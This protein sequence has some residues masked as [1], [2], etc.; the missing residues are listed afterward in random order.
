MELASLWMDLRRSRETSFE[1]SKA[2]WPL[3]AE[4]L[5]RASTS[6][7]KPKPRAFV[8]TDAF[9]YYP[10]ARVG[11]VAAAGLGGGGG[12]GMG[13]GRAPSSSSSLSSSSSSSS[14]SLSAPPPFAPNSVAAR[15][16]ELEL[17]EEEE[18]ELEDM[19]PPE[20]VYQDEEE[21]EEGV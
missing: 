13:V 15:V 14:L 18:E 8:D 4:Q 6:S 21:V 2:P 20:E 7:R 3:T 16:A 1:L 10:E 9:F 12:V 11:P 17:E 19:V 5:H